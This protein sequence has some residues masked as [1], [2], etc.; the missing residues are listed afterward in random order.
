MCSMNLMC[1]AYVLS[2]SG[3]V[4]LM[5]YFGYMAFM[6]TVPFIPLHIARRVYRAA[7]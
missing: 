2:L 6:L 4:E 5:L 1:V 7:R 3:A